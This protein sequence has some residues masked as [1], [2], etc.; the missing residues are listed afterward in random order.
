MELQKVN[1][2]SKNVKHCGVKTSTIIIIIPCWLK[3]IHNMHQALGCAETAFNFL[4]HHTRQKKEF[5]KKNGVTLL[6]LI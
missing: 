6:L 1:Y 4:L 5:G 3:D 2:F